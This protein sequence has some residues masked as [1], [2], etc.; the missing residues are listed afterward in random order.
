MSDFDT[1][2]LY[3]P[4]MRQFGNINMPQT[5]QKSH[6]TAWHDLYITS[7]RQTKLETHLKLKKLL[8]SGAGR[9]NPALSIFKSKICLYA[10][11]FMAAIL[12]GIAPL[13]A[14]GISNFHGSSPASIDTAHWPKR[15]FNVLSYQLLLDW[16]SVFATHRPVFSGHNLITIQLTDVVDTIVLDAME[17]RIDSLSI[18]GQPLSNLPQPGRDSTLRIPLPVELQQKG[19]PISLGIG[20]TRTSTDDDGLYYYPKGLYVGDGPANDS[21]FVDEDLAYTMSEP[22]DAH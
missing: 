8:T 9:A 22:L 4:K 5:F 6:F 17:M 21:I 15:P 3:I 10:A 2:D 7:Q 11:I 16:R 12:V 19:T 14:R 20:F 1:G 13:K 18:N